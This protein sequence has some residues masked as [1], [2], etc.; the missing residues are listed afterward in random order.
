[1]PDVSLLDYTKKNNILDDDLFD[2]LYFDIGCMVY[3]YGD[4][5]INPREKMLHHKKGFKPSLIEQFIKYNV[6]LNLLKNRKRMKKESKI[7]SNS[8]FTINLELELLGYN[9]YR[10]IW[11][12]AYRQK[13]CAHISLFNKTKYIKNYI[14]NKNFIDIISPHFLKTL[15][16]YRKEMM[17]FYK[18]QNVMALFVPNDISFMENFTIKIFKEIEKPSFIFLHGLPGRYNPIDEN[19]S[20]YLIVW[21][22][23]IKNLYIKVGVSEDKILVSGHP[24][25]KQFNATNLRFS[26]DNILIIT[27]S[28][29]GSQFSD[30]IRLYDR[31]NLIVY[32]LQIEKV[33][34]NLGIK[35]VRLRPHPSE[36][37]TWYY[38]FIDKNFF[39]ADMDI[40]RDSLI[41][42]TLVIGPASTVFLEAIYY[43]VNYV[44]FEPSI[45]NSDITNFELVPPFDGS[46]REVPVAKT[47]GELKKILEDKITID[48]IIFNRFVKSPFDIS[49]IKN[50][51]EKE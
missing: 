39:K 13:C 51:L 46:Y 10:P 27:K 25:Y 45:D 18:K 20:D 9:V 23:E 19:R 21:G 6:Y 22:E 12:P 32:L 41:K 35:S 42:A 8:Y 33:L 28:L 2:S 44:I 4:H 50:I 14:H 3:Y 47:E 43:G 15:Q 40:F 1:M 16:A 38:K 37:I 31:G 29:P 34:K 17:D 49:C 24:Y 30:K 5:F 7:I 48:P 26:F 11:A 36:N